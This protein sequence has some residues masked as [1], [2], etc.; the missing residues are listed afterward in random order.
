MIVAAAWAQK[1][2]PRRLRFRNRSYAVGVTAP[3]GVEPKRA[4]L[5]TRTSRPP[6]V[7]AA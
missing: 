3:K 2:G 1:K 6:S 7:A 4:A 5:L